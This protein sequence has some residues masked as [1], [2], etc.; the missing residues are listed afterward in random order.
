MLSEK[1]VNLQLYSAERIIIMEKR[2]HILLVEDDESI[3]FGLQDILEGQ[4]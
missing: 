1:E 4:G 2:K 3:L